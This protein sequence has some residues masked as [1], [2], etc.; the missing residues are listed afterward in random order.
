MLKEQLNAFKKAARKFNVYA[1]DEEQAWR[2]GTCYVQRNRLMHAAIHNR[3]T[4]IRGMPMMTTNDAEGIMQTL[5][6]LRGAD[7][8]KNREAWRGGN[9]QLKLENLNLQGTAQSWRRTVKQGE[10]WNDSK[11][12]Q[13]NKEEGPEVIRGKCNDEVGRDHLPWMQRV[14]EGERKQIKN[15]DGVLTNQMQR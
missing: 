9:L 4:A 13:P 6:A 5:L 10:V 12:Q 14:P 11:P 15:Q 8:K 3:Q 1:V 7:K 2:L